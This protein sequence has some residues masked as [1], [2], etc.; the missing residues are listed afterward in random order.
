[1]V[2]AERY[3]ALRT[4]GKTIEEARHTVEIEARAL[5]NSLAA[6]EHEEARLEAMRQQLRETGIL[7]SHK[8]VAA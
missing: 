5:V 4:A 1:M 8:A 6:K 3:A 2:V 7:T